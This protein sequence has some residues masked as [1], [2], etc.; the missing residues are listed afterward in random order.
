M[1]EQDYYDKTKK[2]VD[3]AGKIFEGKR[4]VEEHTVEKNGTHFRAEEGDWVIDGRPVSPEDIQTW[5]SGIE[6]TERDM[7]DVSGLT[8]LQKNVRG[9]YEGDLTSVVMALGGEVGSLQDFHT[10]QRLHQS[11]TDS[12]VKQS[13]STDCERESDEDT[14]VEGVYAD[15]VGRIIINTIMV[16]EETNIDVQDAVEQVYENWSETK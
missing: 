3:D 8:E 4:V 13:V 1:T 10:Y 5:Y 12:D 9:N 16:A 15:H 14:D 2:F 11:E 6:E 7:G